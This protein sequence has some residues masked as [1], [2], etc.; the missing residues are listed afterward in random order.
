MT[1]VLNDKTLHSII[2]L[3]VPL[4]CSSMESWCGRQ[5]FVLLSWQLGDK[6]TN[7]DALSDRYADDYCTDK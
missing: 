7:R 2:Q 3:K 5:L 4:S 1:N 6:E